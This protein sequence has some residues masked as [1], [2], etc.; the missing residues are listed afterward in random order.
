M[1]CTE[2][3]AEPETNGKAQPAFEPESPP[4]LD[5]RLPLN[6]RQLFLL[7]KSWKGISRNMEA[8]GVEVFMK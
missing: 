3:K 1:G 5:P 7:Q 2:S 4:P 6:R 8:A